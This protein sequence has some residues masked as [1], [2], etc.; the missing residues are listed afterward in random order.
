MEIRGFVRHAGFTGQIG[1]DYNLHNPFWY[2]MWRVNGDKGWTK[3]F[4]VPIETGSGPGHCPLYSDAR[5]WL[6]A[7]LEKS[8]H[9]Q[10][11]M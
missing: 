11:F 6:M 3:W 7:R 2:R 9:G 8:G 5:E 4:K 10:R 1:E